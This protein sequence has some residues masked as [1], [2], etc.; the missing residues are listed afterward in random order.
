MGT[1]QGAELS[2]FIAFVAC[3]GQKSMAEL[4]YT[5]LPP[6][7]VELAFQAAGRLPGGVTPPPPTA[8]NCPNPTIT[9][10][11]NSISPVGPLISQA[12]DG[13]STLPVSAATVGDAWV[14][15]VRVKNSSADVSSISGG[16]VG[17]HWTKLTRVSDAT[18][19]EDVEE[20]LGPISKTGASAVT[21]HFSESN[22]GQR[23]N[24]RRKSSRTAKV[25]R[26]SGPMTW[27]RSEERH[28]VFDHHLPDPDACFQR[29]ALCRL[30]PGQFQLVCRCHL[31]IR[32]R[33][34]QREKPSP[35]TTPTSRPASRPP[36]RNKTASRSPRG[37]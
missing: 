16:G 33:E 15:A 26:R 19:N 20:W 23:W 1:A 5:P 35:S 28:A 34:R 6:N 25:P 30:Q 9:G 18:Q 4:G 32:L 22:R 21:V 2:Q 14:L 10:G 37:R 11:L 36:R 29:R 3:L 17:G 13:G 31:R 7:L 27:R 12:S 24:S 8:A